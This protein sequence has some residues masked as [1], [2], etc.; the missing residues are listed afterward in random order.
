MTAAGAVVTQIALEQP[1]EA[2]AELARFHA[3]AVQQFQ[4]GRKVGML[5]QPYLLLAVGGLDAEGHMARL[6]VTRQFAAGEVVHDRIRDAPRVADAG[7]KS[8]DL[9]PQPLRGLRHLR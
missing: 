7:A 1:L 5:D 3:V 8:A 6:P 2:A 4:Q 9:L